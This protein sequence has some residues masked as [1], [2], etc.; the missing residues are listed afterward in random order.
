MKGNKI[1]TCLFLVIPILLNACQPLVDQPAPLETRPPS[2]TGPATE[3]PSPLTPTPIATPASQ[4]DAIPATEVWLPNEKIMILEPAP[5]SRVV[6]PV[7]VSGAADSTFEQTLV[8]R[9]LLDDGT[10][11]AL[12]PTMIRA[13]LGQR[14]PFEV[15]LGFIVEGERQAFIQVYDQSARDGEIIHLAAVGVLASQTG[16]EEIRRAEPRAEQIIILQPTVRERVQGGL[17]VVRGYGWAGFEQSLLIEVQDENGTVVGSMP[18]LVDAPDLGQPG[19]F[20]AEIPYQVAKEGV[21]RILVRDISPAFGGDVH[22]TSVD[23][24]LAP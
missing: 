18:V 3:L 11:I 23:I 6:S 8:V 10:E 22:R 5:G 13:E 1:A 21:G 9:M 20:S 16:P 12:Q 4:E 15:E 7:R 14:G 19:H 24:D 17:V 2:G